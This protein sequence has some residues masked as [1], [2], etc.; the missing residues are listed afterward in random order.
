ML[1]HHG[2]LLSDFQLSPGADKLWREKLSNTPGVFFKAG[3]K[4][5]QAHEV[6]IANHDQFNDSKRNNFLHKSSGV[7]TERLAKMKWLHGYRKKDN[8]KPEIKTD[9]QQASTQEVAAQPAPAKAKPA[10]AKVKKEPPTLDYSKI[11]AKQP[12]PES[13]DAGEYWKEPSVKHSD[14]VKQNQLKNKMLERHSKNPETELVQGKNKTIWVK[15]K[16][17]MNKSS[18]LRERIA[19][20][21]TKYE[22]G[23]AMM[24]YQDKAQALH[25]KYNSL[26]KTAAP[27]TTGQMPIADQMQNTAE[28][29]LK[30]NQSADQMQNTAEPMLKDNQ[31]HAAGSPAD[32]A[33]DV[34]EGVSTLKAEL[35]QQ[36]TSQKRSDLL[37]HLKTL[38]ESGM[39][40]SKENAKVGID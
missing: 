19:K 4:P 12:N 36:Q 17:K 21:K 7:L 37:K 29:M 34:A 6:W 20:L 25:A 35:Q 15:N 3:D 39:L 30:D 24:S 11:N 28:P 40:R 5:H 18:E 27:V 26:S 32:S 2:H 38:K 33:H 31:P 13:A 8:K 14:I 23:K 9:A 16:E 1:A 10:P 22:H